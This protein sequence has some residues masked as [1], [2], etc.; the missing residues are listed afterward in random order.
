MRTD[1]D[2]WILLVS[3]SE[4]LAHD[5]REQLTSEL[6]AMS[7]PTRNI[8]LRRLRHTLKELATMDAAVSE[9]TDG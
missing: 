2:F 7:P 4:R 5:T 9:S 6:K 1:S 8:M 3:I